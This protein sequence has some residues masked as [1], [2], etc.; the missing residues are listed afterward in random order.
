[1][2]EVPP[3]TVGTATAGT[4]TEQ[5]IRSA[6]II[7]RNGCEHSYK[8]TTYDLRLGI[9]FLRPDNQDGLPQK[10]MHKQP[11]EIPPF[12]SVIVSTHE[13]LSMPNNVVGRFNLKIRFALQGLFVQMGT[14][15][16]PHYNGRLFALL[17]NITNSTIHLKP[18]NDRIF[19]IEFSF[20]C[21]PTTKVPPKFIGREY[22]EIADFLEPDHHIINGTINHLTAHL[23]CKIADL[24][25]RLPAVMIEEMKEGIS[26]AT[27]RVFDRKVL[28]YGSIAFGSVTL[29][30]AAVIP[31]VMTIVLDYSR[32]VEVST[33]QS[34]VQ[35]INSTLGGLAPVTDV[36][37]LQEKTDVEL[38]LLRKRIQDLESVLSSIVP[39]DSNEGVSNP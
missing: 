36:E 3:P 1:M 14:Q 18:T 39:V 33:L 37:S 23:E 13:I 29:F 22:L 25:E 35:S 12:S 16:E 8:P 24:N 17:Q 5:E 4:L 7:S 10:L 31:F 27:T 30:L 19:A 34:E 9:E 32:P 2:S 21:Q 15:V 28:G 26:H 6:N 38:D 11:L 20:L